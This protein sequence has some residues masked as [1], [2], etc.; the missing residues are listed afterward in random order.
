MNVKENFVQCE[1]DYID[2]Y[3]INY[4]RLENQLS[5]SNVKMMILCSPHNP[6]GRVWS[7]EEILKVTKLCEKYNVILISDEIHCDLTFKEKTHVMSHSLSDWAKNNTITYIAPT[8]TFIAGRTPVAYNNHSFSKLTLC[9][10]FYTSLPQN[11]SMHHLKHH[12]HISHGR[13]ALKSPQLFLGQ[14]ESPYLLLS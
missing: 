12:S 3:Y 14:Q 8:K 5:N 9:T 7:K 11:H 10:F 1:L 6:L 4:E 2:D 13:L